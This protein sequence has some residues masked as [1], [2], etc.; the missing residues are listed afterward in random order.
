MMVNGLQSDGAVQSYFNDAMNQEVSYQTSGIGA[1]T[2]AGGVRLNMIP[3]EGGNRFSGDFKS[4]Y[5]PGK[6]QANNLTERHIDKGLRTGNSTDRI[7]DFT[8]AEGGPIKRDKLWF[9][10]SGRYISVNNFIPDTFYPDGSKGLDDQFIKSGLGRVTWQLSPRNKFSAYFDEVDKFRGHDLQAL[11]DPQTAATVWYSPAYHTTA[12]KWTSTV[13]NRLLIE[14]G[15]SNNTENYTN[16]YLPGVDQLRG[17]IWEGGRRP[18]RR[19]PPRVPYGL[20]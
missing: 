11:Y 1:D 14:G 6:W 5:R 2:Q 4:A 9:F 7:I 15:W 18:R 17:T 3:R 16:S 19:R 8:G 13:T 12:A 20:P 10:V